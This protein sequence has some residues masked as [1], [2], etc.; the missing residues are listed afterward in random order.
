MKAWRRKSRPSV[1]GG[2]DTGVG[3]QESVVSNNSWNIS[4]LHHSQLYIISPVNWIFV[5]WNL[6]LH[7]DNYWHSTMWPDH[8]RMVS[9]SDTL[10]EPEEER[11]WELALLCYLWIAV[12]RVCCAGLTASHCL[13]HWDRLGT[14]VTTSSSSSVTVEDDNTRR[15]AGK[16]WEAALGLQTSRRGRLWISF[17]HTEGKDRRTSPALFITGDTPHTWH[18]QWLTTFLGGDWKDPS[19]LNAFCLNGG[20]R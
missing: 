15:Q 8:S 2:A 11:E 4:P 16:G 17:D 6:K 10:P 3:R 7:H 18:V 9:D 14:S 20:V 1:A 19:S 13:Q 5:H 12:S